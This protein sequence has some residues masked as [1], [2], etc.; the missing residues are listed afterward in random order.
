[1]MHFLKESFSNNFLS[2]IGYLLCKSA[3]S[4]A[5][6]TIDKRYYNGAPFLGLR[7]IAIKSHGD[8]DAVGVA[9]AIKV[10]IEMVKNKLPECLEK[11]LTMDA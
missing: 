8:S 9:N 10:A 5:Y 7:G 11:Q 3:L 2:K 4:K 1:V 6:K